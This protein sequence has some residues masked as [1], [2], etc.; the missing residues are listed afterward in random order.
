M[1]N[2]LVARFQ[3]SLG[4]V[5]RRLASLT[6]GQGTGE[7]GWNRIVEI[8]ESHNLMSAMPDPTLLSII[9]AANV[10]S[11]ALLN[12]TKSMIGGKSSNFPSAAMD[13]LQ[14]AAVS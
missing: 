8:N 11:W 3:T 6:Y 2:S 12:A 9:K 14:M 5:K 10:D 13:C 7:S 1:A 4:T